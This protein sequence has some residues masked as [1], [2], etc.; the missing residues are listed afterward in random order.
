MHLTSPLCIGGG[1]RAC[2]LKETDHFCGCQPQKQLAVY[3]K[4]P[5]LEADIQVL[6]ELDLAT[7]QPTCQHK[8][9]GRPRGFLTEG[10]RLRLRLSA[11]DSVGDS[12][13]DTQSGGGYSGL[14]GTRLE[15][16]TAKSSAVVAFPS[17]ASGVAVAF[18]DT[19]GW[20]FVVLS[21]VAGV[22][23]VL[24]SHVFPTL[25]KQSYHFP[26]FQAE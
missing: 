23:V 25:Q 20:I 5:K 13:K 6:K 14:Q 15:D 10:D 11:P 21:E 18:S 7:G 17:V 26:T 2:W 1:P 24:F 16:E 19:A 3:L 9:G 8:N 4:R 12:P 22:A